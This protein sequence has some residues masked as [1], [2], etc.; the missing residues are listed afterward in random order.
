MVVKDPGSSTNPQNIFVDQDVQPKVK[1]PSLRRDTQKSDVIYISSSMFSR[2]S[3]EKLSSKTQRAHT[4][5][6]SG[7]D[8]HEML[9]HLIADPKFQGINTANVSKVFILCGTNDVQKIYCGKNLHDSYQSLDKI[10]LYLYNTF[11][12]ATINIINLFSRD[13]KGC[14]DII[15]ELNGHILNLSDTY[16][17]MKFIDTQDN[18][19]FSDR[20]GH[21]RKEFFHDEVHL[22]NNGIV[23]LCKHL[24]YISHDN[25]I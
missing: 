24:K 17:R 20:T 16:I 9:N 15:K 22:N 21:R 23:R 14:N 4:F 6:Y 11:Y 12:K 18:F 5:S 7:K 13:F 2:F 19:M 8:S 10:F 3:S 1:Q 25:E